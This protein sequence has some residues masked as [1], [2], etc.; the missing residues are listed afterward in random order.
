M[1]F[2][3]D[4]DFADFQNCTF[5]QQQPQSKSEASLVTNNDGQ[6]EDFADFQNADLVVNADHP[7]LTETRQVSS[8]SINENPKFESILKDAF[9]NLDNVNKEAANQTVLINELFTDEYKRR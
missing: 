4:D 7:N 9:P 3:E 8:S 6:D 5:E 2:N 1:S